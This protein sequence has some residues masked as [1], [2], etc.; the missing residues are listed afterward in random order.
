[1]LSLS[2]IHQAAYAPCLRSLASAWSLS[3]IY[4][5]HKECPGSV[6]S[7]YGDEC[8]AW[9]VEFC[10]MDYRKINSSKKCPNGNVLDG[11]TNKSCD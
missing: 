10:N 5:N 6:V 2:I 11:I 1:M 8:T 9:V 3:Y 7:G 4:E